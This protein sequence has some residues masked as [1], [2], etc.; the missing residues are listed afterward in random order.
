ML[1]PLQHLSLIIGVFNLLH[2]DDLRLLQ[3]LD[4]IVAL[5]VLGLHEM[6]TTKRAR[7]QCSLNG[8][9]GE[10]VFP[11]GLSLSRLALD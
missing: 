9:V 1:D 11:L 8:E 3:D 5:V 4:G 7:A 6:Y 2:L 10:R